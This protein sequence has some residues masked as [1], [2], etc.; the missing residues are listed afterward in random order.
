MSTGNR[1]VN[2]APRFP[3]FAGLIIPKG[4]SASSKRRCCR[5]TSP[6]GGNSPGEKPLVFWKANCAGN[7]TGTF[8]VG[9]RDRNPPKIGRNGT[10]SWIAAGSAGTHGRSGGNFGS[11]WSGSVKRGA[12]RHPPL[13]GLDGKGSVAKR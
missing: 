13:G 12:G 5:L 2:A 3:I 8:F 7:G 9:G 6:I 4:F 10:E 11:Y 1:D